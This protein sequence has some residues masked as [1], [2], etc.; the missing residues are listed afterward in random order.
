MT[1]CSAPS[2]AFGNVTVKVTG[3]TPFAGAGVVTV[4]AIKGGS[5][6]E[7]R[8][9]YRRERRPGLVVGYERYGMDLVDTERPSDAVALRMNAVA[10]MYP[11]FITKKRQCLTSFVVTLSPTVAYHFCPG[12]GCG[13]AGGFAPH[14]T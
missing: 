3:G 2:P 12:V 10:R 8:R 13:G 5:V 9:N 6:G 7:P 14:S 4:C 11:D 1:A